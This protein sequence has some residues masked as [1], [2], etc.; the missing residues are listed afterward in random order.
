[1]SASQ[2]INPT[3]GLGELAAQRTFFWRVAALT[4]LLFLCL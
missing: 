2:F 3:R 4:L 1:M